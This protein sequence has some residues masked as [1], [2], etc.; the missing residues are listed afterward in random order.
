MLFQARK[1]GSGSDCDSSP[2]GW[3]SLCRWRS[4]RKEM[5][6]Q[7]KAQRADTV[8]AKIG[9]LTVSALRAFQ[10]FKNHFRGL[11]GPGRGCVGPVGPEIARFRINR[12]PTKL[13]SARWCPLVKDFGKLFSVVAG[14]LQRI[15]AHRGK[16]CSRRYRT[17]QETRE[18]LA[19]V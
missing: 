12:R 19:T 16:G 7:F 5:I 3:H 8:P 1:G 14:Q 4:H 17:R 9:G 6:V 10:S 11:I 2:E 13:E 15:D 18:L